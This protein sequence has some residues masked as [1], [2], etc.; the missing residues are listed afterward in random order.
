MRPLICPMLL[1][2]AT[3][4]A[5]GCATPDGANAAEKRTYTLD[6]RKSALDAF[7]ESYPDVKA[8]AN[9]AAGTMFVSAFSVHPG[10]LTIANGYGVI[11][12]S[13]TGD[14][15]YIR[16]NRFGI[17]P[18]LAV[19]GYYLL[20]IFES[21]T[22]VQEFF[23]GAFS[24]GGFAEASFIFGNTGG[25]A[26]GTIPVNEALDAYIW[27]HTGVSLELTM[28]GAWITVEDDLN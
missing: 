13:Q 24:G 18:G 3:I 20:V 7:Y 15:R 17:G 25:C 28:A 12:N 4:L 14:R 22:T 1:A 11:E 16:L 27:S 2:A 26:A 21:E 8:K 9:Q 23:S 6:V 19:K 10:L 5:T